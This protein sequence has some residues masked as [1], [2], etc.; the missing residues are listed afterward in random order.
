MNETAYKHNSLTIKALGGGNT[1]LKVIFANILLLA[2]ISCTLL[3]SCSDEPDNG[4][5][6]RPVVVSDSLCADDEWSDT[7]DI[8]FSKR[9]IDAR[10]PD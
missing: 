9:R 1:F 2:A 10:G 4:S 6:T 3:S 5:G 7:I 8:S